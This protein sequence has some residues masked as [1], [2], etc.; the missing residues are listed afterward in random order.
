M[1]ID[2]L[3]ELATAKLGT[4]VL[5]HRT[6]NL[7][8]LKPAYGMVFAEFTQGYEYWAFGDED[9]LYGDLD[10]MLAPELNAA[11]DMVIPGTSSARMEGNVQGHLTVLRNEPR[12]N[13][14]A[15]R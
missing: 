3:R 9:V 8:D 6:R 12:T 2:R 15:I 7:C 13:E 5:L 1:T 11:P 4:P 14:L 10:G